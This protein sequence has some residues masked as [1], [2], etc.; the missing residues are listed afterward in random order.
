MSKNEQAQ[1]LCDEILE[2]IHSDLSEK[3][4]LKAQEFFDS[5]DEGVKD[6]Q[7]RLERGM[8]PT[9][10]QMRTL[11]NWHHGVSKWIK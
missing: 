6:M 11:D 10:S 3:A 5:I 2:M 9:E 4:Y 8:E 1:E 7:E